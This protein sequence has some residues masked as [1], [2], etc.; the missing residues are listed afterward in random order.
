MELELTKDGAF[1]IKNVTE[2]ALKYIR[3]HA[4]S[5]HIRSPFQQKP[6]ENIFTIFICE[7]FEYSCE[8]NGKRIEVLE[9]D[10]GLK[11]SKSARRILDLW[12]ELDWY[13]ETLKSEHEKGKKLKDACR[14]Y[15]H[16]KEEGCDI[17]LNKKY[18]MD[19]DVDVGYCDYA[20]EELV[21]GGQVSTG[22]FRSGI[23]KVT[24]FAK[25]W[26]PC[27][28]CQYKSEI[29]KAMEEITV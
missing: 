22:I 16:H 1:E 21:F 11:I 2:E 28:N 13:K 19:G 18:F 6:G 4:P 20:Q 25:K 10:Y 17:C 14:T 3:E 8:Y 7:D 26:F 29:K 23:A 24:G 12:R 5:F 9:Q 27:E 15:F